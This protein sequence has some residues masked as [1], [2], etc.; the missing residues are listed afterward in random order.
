MK[1]KTKNITIMVPITKISPTIRFKYPPISQ[2]TR[3][4]LILKTKK[5]QRH[6]C[7]TDIC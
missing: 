1:E 5:K 3:Y 4:E 7:T 2:N 6:A